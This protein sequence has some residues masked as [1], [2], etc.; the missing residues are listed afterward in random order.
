MNES[1]GIKDPLG[2]APQ[3]VFSFN[4]QSPEQEQSLS[5]SHWPIR[6]AVVDAGELGGVRGHC[7]F[8]TRVRF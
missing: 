3:R 7:R 1:A 5:V 4:I 2:S 6:A 8:M